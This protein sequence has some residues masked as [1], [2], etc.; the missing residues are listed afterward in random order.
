[1]NPGRERKAIRIA[2]NVTED[3][4]RIIEE[5]MRKNEII[6]ISAFCRLRILGD[7]AIPI[8]RFPAS[9]MELSD[10]LKSLHSNLNQLLRQSHISGLDSKLAEDLKTICI[11]LDKSTR[12][13]RGLLK[14]E[15]PTSAVRAMAYERFTKEDAM[16]LL[17]KKRMLAN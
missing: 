5:E 10:S 14:A 8:I 2:T 11:D 7:Y 6:S 13:L 16:K 9:N 4:L 1:M 12:E 17:F 3:E 15:I